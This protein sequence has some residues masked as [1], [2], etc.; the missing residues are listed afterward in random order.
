MC[1]HEEERRG[2]TFQFYLFTGQTCI[3]ETRILYPD[4]SMKITFEKERL[5]AEE[6]LAFCIERKEE[7]IWIDGRR[8]LV[9]GYLFFREDI[10][11]VVTIQ[12]VTGLACGRIPFDFD[13]KIMIGSDFKNEIFYECFTFLKDIKIVLEKKEATYLLLLDGKCREKAGIYINDRIAG[14][15]NS[16]NVGDCIRIFG[17]VIWILPGLVVCHAFFGTLRVA[18]RRDDMKLLEEKRESGSDKATGL[19]GVILRQERQ[20]EG[21]VCKEEIELECWQPAL[22]EA[23]A[24]LF[25]QI[26]PMVTMMVPSLVMMLWGSRAGSGSNIYMMTA[27]MTGTSVFF[28]VLWSVFGRLFKRRTDK[29]KERQK[30]DEYLRYLRQTDIWLEEKG[31]KQKELLLKKYPAFI[32]FGTAQEVVVFWSSVKEWKSSM[33]LRLGLGEDRHSVT[34]RTMKKH[35]PGKISPFNEEADRVQKKHQKIFGV[36]VGI[37]L[38]KYGNTGFC[39]REIY[40]FLGQLLLLMAATYD[41]REVKLIYFYRKEMKRQQE[42]ANILKWLPQIWQEDKKRR[43]LAGSDEE[44]G[45]LLPV[46]TQELLGRS[47]RNSDKDDVYVFLITDR[48]CMGGEEFEHFL[49]EGHQEGCYH[50]F[51]IS[52][53]AEELQG[54]YLQIV[55]KEEEEILLTKGG[56]KQR[57]KEEEINAFGAQLYARKLANVTKSD[58]EK[59]SI[60]PEKVSFLELFDCQ[61]VS[62]LHCLSRWHES[63][64]SKRIRVPIGF[65]VGRKKIY[66]DIHERFHGPHGLLAGTTGSGKSE[67][68]QTFLLSLSVSF[69]PEAINFFIIDYKGGGLGQGLD[70]LPHCAGVISNLSGRQIRRALLSIKSENV[71]RQ[72]LLADA[73]VNHVDDYG[74]LYRE[75]TV[76]EPMPHLVLVV[77][78]FA[79]LKKE[80]PEF[81]QEIISMAQIG[82]SLG[83]HLLLSTQK[84]AGTVDD[85]IW[86]NTRFRL[87]LRVAEKQD[88]MDMLHRPEAAFL[89]GAGRCYLQVGNQEIFEVFQTG[90]SKASYGTDEKDDVVLISNTGKRCVKEKKRCEHCR[91]QI[92]EVSNYVNQMAKK[93]D[94]KSARMLWMDELPEQLLLQE[95]TTGGIAEGKALGEEPVFMLGK[96]D[97]PGRQKQG[98][99]FYEPFKEGHLCICGMSGAGKST[100]LQTILWQLCESYSPGRLQFLLVHSAYAGINCFSSMP[101]CMGSLGGIE[102]EES[103]FYQ[104]DKLIQKRKRMLKGIPWQQ[105]EQQTGKSMSAVLV[106]I[107][108]YGSFRQMINER[109][110]SLI[111]QIAKEG[112]GYGIYLVISALLAGGGE[113]PGK[114]FEHIRKTF[115]LEMSDSVQYGDVMRQYRMMTMPKCGIKGRGICRIEDEVLE[116]QSAVFYEDNDFGRIRRVRERALLITQKETAVEKFLQIPQRPDKEQVLQVWKKQKEAEQKWQTDSR[117]QMQLPLGYQMKNGYMQEISMKE[118]SVFL[119]SGEKNADKQKVLDF[120]NYSAVNVGIDTIRMDRKCRFDVWYADVISEPT[121]TCREVLL[122]M[123]DSITDFTDLLIEKEGMTGK[124]MLYL[125][126]R[127]KEKSLWLIAALDTEKEASLI[128]S[129]WYELFEQRQCGIHLGGNA[130][131]Q[132]I[133]RFDELGYA[134]LLKREEKGIGYLKAG[135]GEEMKKILL[136]VFEKEGDEDDIGGYPDTGA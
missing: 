17:L 55:E 30:E 33:F 43:F 5:E 8:V 76:K 44:I 51:F 111:E 6:M 10:L 96:Y 93:A 67:L 23:E 45:E 73:G 125:K 120:L 69:R 42:L 126:E 114:V 31:K 49:K 61:S 3:R 118:H 83:V 39:G 129:F 77:D 82:R 75:G 97:N 57:V 132:R 21:E 121:A 108:D 22:N 1:A 107:D 115:S 127:I 100:F 9:P 20:E 72:R 11:L 133:F 94:C 105:Y 7:A 40:S 63:D 112:T 36:P 37:D 56:E 117:R 66:L 79:E 14:E 18:E 19:A 81:M 16:L 89:E 122:L 52:E 109:E 123:I 110:Q 134:D 26:G 4:E 2:E 48:S 70:T 86:S 131:N 116:F 78:E 35:Q 62:Q 71:R 50:M 24:P 106:I 13:R 74:A 65:G 87:C 84:P 95:I 128:G 135:I 99:V 91:T 90:Y 64:T 113:L 38:R 88:S 119:V 32:Q 59:A 47:S 46:L 136:P 103:F 130:V 29:R 60:M 15:K 101:H 54:N 80:E 68:L 28:M 12:E 27:V 58:K 53:S 98:I 102:N 25:L 41:K 85:R 34:V 92:Q 124:A 104:L